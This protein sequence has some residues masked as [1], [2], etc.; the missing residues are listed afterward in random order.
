MSSPHIAGIGALIR[1]QHP[2][3]SPAA[4]KS[5]LMTTAT[6]RRNDG[7]AIREDSD[8]RASNPFGYGAGFVQ[9]NAAL[10]P[11][12]VYDAGLGR[13]ARLHLRHGRGAASRPSQP[14][15]PSNLNYP[16]HLP[17]AISSVSRPCAARSPT[18]VQ[19]TATYTAQRQRAGGH[20]CRSASPAL[21]PSRR[22]RVAAFRSRFTRVDS[23]LDRYAFGSL[24][25]SDGQHTRAQ[26]HRDPL[27]SARRPRR[28]S[29]TPAAR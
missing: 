29:R 15:D 12:L 21:S 19:R 8:G 20:Q 2:D 14:I 26:P 24:T 23:R 5:A 1:Q 3:W 16:F 13:L 25:W 28:N 9:P 10:D 6:P 27:W 22:A 11:G 7:T 4:I 17:L 18:S